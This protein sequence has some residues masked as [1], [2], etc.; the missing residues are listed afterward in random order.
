MAADAGVSLGV[1]AAGLAIRQTG[2]DWI[3]PMISLAIVVVIVIGTWGLLRDSVN[4]A[5]DAVPKDIDLE[6]VRRFLESQVEV[7]AV[8]DLHVWAMS[9][10]ETALTVH[11]V[12]QQGLDAGFLVRIRQS[13]RDSFHISHTTIQ[14]ESIDDEQNC[15]GDCA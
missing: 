9:T 12:T 2:A 14:L 1:V 5:L 3:D 6:E 13:L 7:E 4:L 10:T 8:H 15:D 11:L